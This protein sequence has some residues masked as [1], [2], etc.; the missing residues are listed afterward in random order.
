MKK[1]LTII[2]LCASFFG[3]AQTKQ[4]VTKSA[5]TYQV[6]NMGFNSTGK[7]G[8]PEADIVFDNAHLNTSHIDASINVKTIDSDDETRDEHLRNLDFFDAD[9]YPK[10]TLKSVSI[11]PK[12]GNNFTGQFDLTIKG[13][14]KRIN[15]PFT[16]VTKGNTAVFTASFKIN[17]LDFGVGDTSMVLSNEV[18][19]FL[20]AETGF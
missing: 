15:L 18:T 12:G 3:F 5:V 8:P 1:T 9:H 16:C 4:T 20:T 19:I 10:I 13:K 17:R 2:L 7:F 11:Q 14:T 6:K